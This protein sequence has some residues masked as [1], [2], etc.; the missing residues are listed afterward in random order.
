MD[1]VQK[2]TTKEK[3][4]VEL[5]SDHP[6]YILTQKEFIQVKSMLINMRTVAEF[7]SSFCST[8]DA[9]FIEKL[10]MGNTEWDM[11][12]SSQSLVSSSVQNDF[13]RAIQRTHSAMFNQVFILICTLLC[14]VFTG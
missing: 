9:V 13:H 14:L 8:N 5:Y 10:K 1:E 2:C 3:I 12:F 4:T 11:Y 6:C 7:F